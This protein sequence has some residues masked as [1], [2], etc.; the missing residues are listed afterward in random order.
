[1]WRVPVIVIDN[2]N[3][4]HKRLPDH[5]ITGAEQQ[6]LTPNCGRNSRKAHRYMGIIFKLHTDKSNYK[7]ATRFLDAK[8]A[9]ISMRLATL[10]AKRHSQ[11]QLGHEHIGFILF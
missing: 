9:V 4:Q 6:Y 11:Q 7:R 3:H 2:G 5:L 10:K 8:Q 1:M